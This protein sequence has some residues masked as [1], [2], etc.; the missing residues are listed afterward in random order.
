MC[1]AFVPKNFVHCTKVRYSQIRTQPCQYNRWKVFEKGFGE[2]LFLKK[3]FPKKPP[4]K[5]DVR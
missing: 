2:K 3:F 1:R 4:L 5:D